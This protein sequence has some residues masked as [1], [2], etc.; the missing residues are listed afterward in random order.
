MLEFLT[1]NRF[2]HLKTCS[3]KFDLHEGIMV[4]LQQEPYDDENLDHRQR[5]ARAESE[6]EFP[7]LLSS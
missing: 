1:R 7:D 3:E 6:L 2:S 5:R 4:V